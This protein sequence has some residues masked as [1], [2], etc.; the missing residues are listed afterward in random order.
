MDRAA[1]LREQIYEDSEGRTFERPTRCNSLLLQKRERWVP[2]EKP[3]KGRGHG[4]LSRLA[5]ES[6]PEPIA[7]DPEPDTVI[8]TE[9]DGYDSDEEDRRNGVPITYAQDQGRA[10][11][12][13]MRNE[14]AAEFRR[15]TLHGNELA[16]NL[17]RVE[18]SY[19][20]LRRQFFKHFGMNWTASAWHGF[21]LL[22]E[23]IST[24][25]EQL[26]DVQENLE[27]RYAEMY[28][29]LDHPRPSKTSS[30][31]QQENGTCVWTLEGTA[32]CARNDGYLVLEWNGVDYNSLG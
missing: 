6:R 15:L 26:F 22:D 31:M 25:Q 17:H 18:G 27:H 19:M 14:M 12:E 7:Q 10:Y 28:S 23:T 30:W 13:S 16:A 5:L 2:A 32:H 20:S 24:L 9:E 4:R 21:L 11:H 8:T 29:L 1:A 3:A